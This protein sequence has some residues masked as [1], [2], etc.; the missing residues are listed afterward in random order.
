MVWRPIVWKIKTEANTIVKKTQKN[1]QKRIILACLVEAL[2]GIQKPS[3][4]TRCKTPEEQVHLLLTTRKY[5][6]FFIV[7]MGKKDIS[8]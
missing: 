2:R 8:L 3:R 7:A 5:I 4:K 1:S 6:S